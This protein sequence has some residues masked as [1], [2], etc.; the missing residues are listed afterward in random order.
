MVQELRH[1]GSAGREGSGFR[2]KSSKSG[3]GL[4]GSQSA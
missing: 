1:S 3:H 4:T 2:A